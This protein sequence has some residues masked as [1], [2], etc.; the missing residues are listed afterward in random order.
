M[1]LDRVNADHQN[2]KL[3]LAQ[4]MQQL[5]NIIAE[6]ER[7][8][9]RSQNAVDELATRNKTL[10]DKHNQLKKMCQE[11]AVALIEFKEKAQEYQKTVIKNQA[12]QG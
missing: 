10:N 6:K 2:E 7:Q 12:L 8:N 3:I 5:E 1:Q 9:K 11:T 4:Q